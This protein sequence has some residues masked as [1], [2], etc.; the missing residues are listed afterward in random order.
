M[1]HKELLAIIKRHPNGIGIEAMLKQLSQPVAKRTLQRHLS[2]LIQAGKIVRKGKGR[3]ILYTPPQ[4]E[5]APQTAATIIYS[6]PA[7]QLKQ[8]LQQPFNLRKKATYQADFLY[9]YQPNADYYLAKTL[10]T[11]LKHLGKQENGKQAAGTFAR[12]I[13]TRFL[14][15]LSWNS[16]RLEGNTYSLLETQRLLMLGEV[17]ANHSNLEAQMILNHKAAIE[18]LVELGEDLAINRYTM[19]N[20]HA[21]L[22]DNLLSNPEAIGRIR[23]IPVSIG[24]TS[25]QPPNIP[26]LLEENFNYIITTANKINDP[27]EQAFFL[28][29]Q[30]PYLQPFEDVN[31]RVSRLAANI[32]FLQQNYCPLSFVELPHRD[33]IDGILGIYELNDISALRD[34]FVWSYECSVKRY[35]SIRDIVSEPDPFKLRYRN[36][37]IDIIA[38]IVSNNIQADIISSFMQQWMNEHINKTDQRRFK[39]IIETELINL[40]AGNIARYRI[41]PTEFKQWYKRWC[42]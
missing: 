38:N 8:Y 34:M 15:D 20:L 31:K 42:S 11:H 27:F 30:L 37:I 25:Y 23:K 33:Y 21:L 13:L 14:L 17:A 18:F 9:H 22:A 28:M 12:T 29:V 39:E 19:L 16:S 24:K 4:A 32:P 1:E 41:K 10:R 2:Y 40:R 6:E 36:E 3:S 26:Q 5:K 35:T 7:K